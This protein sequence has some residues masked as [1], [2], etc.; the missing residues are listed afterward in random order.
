MN[1]ANIRNYIC[2]V[3]AVACVFLGIGAAMPA[4]DSAS[5]CASNSE[6]AL[7]SFLYSVNNTIEEPPV[8]T[9]TMLNHGADAIRGNMNGSFLR[10]QGR[11]VLLFLVVGCSLQYLFCYQSSESKEDGQLFSCRSLIVDYI[12][13]R[14]S[15]E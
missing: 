12:H 2:I 1:G 4:L 13:T 10:W 9:L 8:C 6:G 14:D 3:L 5:L 7:D 11:D 15:G